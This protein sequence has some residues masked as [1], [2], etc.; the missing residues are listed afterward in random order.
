[1]N[2]VRDDT[3]SCFGSTAPLPTMRISETGAPVPSTS[4]SLPF[5]PSI[6]PDAP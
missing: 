1:L 6:T 5:N 3:Q 2:A 4:C